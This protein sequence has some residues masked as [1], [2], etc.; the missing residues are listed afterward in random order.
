MT[1][2]CAVERRC[3]G[4]PGFSPNRSNVRDPVVEVASMAQMP[5]CPHGQRGASLLSLHSLEAF[6]DGG[7][8][9]VA[10]AA[11]YADDLAVHVTGVLACQER[12]HGAAVLV[13]AAQ[14]SHGA[15]HLHDFHRDGGVV[16]ALL[17]VV[18]GD[19]RQKAVGGDAVF[20]QF[21]GAHLR[22]VDDGRLGHAV[23]AGVR[24]VALAGPRRAGEDA[25]VAPLLHGGQAF[26]DHLEG[27][28]GAGA[29]ERHEVVQVRLLERA[30][31]AQGS[32]GDA[33]E[34][35]HLAE[36]V[37][38]GGQDAVEVLLALDV[39]LH[40]KHLAGKPAF[41]RVVA[42]ALQILQPSRAGD[43]VGAS[44]AKRSAAP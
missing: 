18:V 31:V 27:V 8:A 16:G 10:D 34:N 36:L 30:H 14:P 38:A 26:L 42:Q 25:P 21:L 17:E 32:L 20:P 40:G 33:G 7:G 37:K 6:Q 28:T 43:H 4:V 12:E 39:A 13:G 3:C 22:H 41:G 23:G 5:R 24:R 19:D 2:N 29:V 11:A 44:W 1:P 9:G 15:E 35:V